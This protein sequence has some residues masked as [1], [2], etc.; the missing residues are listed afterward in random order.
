MRSKA[1]KAL[2]KQLEGSGEPYSKGRFYCIYRNGRLLLALP[3]ERLLA[4]NVLAL[5]QPQTWKGC[6]VVSLVKLLVRFRLHVFLLPSLL[7]NFRSESPIAALDVSHGSFGFLL[8]NPAST[9]RRVILMRQKNEE[10]FV[11]KIGFSLSARRSV[12]DEASIMRG[13]PSDLRGLLMPMQYKSSDNWAFYS[14][15][16]VEGESPKGEHDDLI[17][18]VLASWCEHGHKALLESIP[19]WALIRDF[20][21]QQDIE[22]GQSLIASCRGLEVMVGISHGDFAPWNVKVT[23]TDSVVVM[24]WEYGSNTG[25]AAWDWIHYLI[26]RSSLVEGNSEKKTI[27]VCR[28]WAKTDR[29]KIFMEESGW[30]SNIELCLGS[31]LIYSNTLGRFD[32][33]ELLS[34]WIKL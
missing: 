15:L 18:D 3:K 11:D 17:L 5:Y 7:L 13:L 12:C 29:G 25:P 28:D 21:Q 2:I 26:Q 14:C 24:D 4:L 9:A 30:G 22:K 20:I 23:G 31:Y 32:H 1:D 8:G 33:E 6:S 10:F 34:E 27:Q 16:F 19:Q